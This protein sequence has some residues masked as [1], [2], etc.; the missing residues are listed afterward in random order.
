MR[1]W[2]IVLAT[3]VAGE[4]SAKDVKVK[5]GTLAPEGSPW[6]NGLLRITQRWSKDSKERVDVK[7]YAGGVL[8]DEGDMIR[9]MRI[10]QLHA[11][12]L[13]GVGLAI[14]TKSTYSL[15]TPM[16]IQSYDELDYVREK[17]GSMIQKE[18]EDNGFVVLGWGDAGWV[19]F[20]AKQ[21][22]TSLADF[23]KLKV[24]VWA[25][26]PGAEMA[27]KA[28]G[29]TPVPMSSTDVMSGLQTG[30]IESF[31]TTPLYA[32]TSQ[33][34]GLAKNMTTVKWTPLNGATVVT[35]KKWDE[36]K[37]VGEL[38]T[39]QLAATEE[40]AKTNAEVRD[41]GDKAI[42][43]MV[44]RGL[45]VH[46]PT[47]GELTEWQAAAKLAYPVL[48]EKVIPEKFF[49]EVARLVAEHRALPKK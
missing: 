13:T 32:L 15:Q 21:P 18:L 16:M 49:D 12:T 34:F 9:K 46:E 27:W 17:M 10:G 42:A 29:F 20:F 26:D 2:F 24:F 37:E 3:V 40:I 35:R 11:G 36:L 45:K 1:G 4:A 25:G 23:R 33:W 43:A 48:R 39:F 7:I 30:L 44:E 22:A 6:H 38:A 8:G 47:A 5:L 31:S 41:L 28:A 14:I 19:H